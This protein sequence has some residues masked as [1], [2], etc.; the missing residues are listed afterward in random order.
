M[1][2]KS[3]R[4]GLILLLQMF[5]VCAVFM[6]RDTADAACGNGKWIREAKGWWY[7]F[8]D[9]SYA[10]SEYIGGYWLNSKGWYEAK[11]NGSWRQNNKGWWFQAGSWYPKNQ[12]L[13]ING[14]SYYFGADGY[15]VTNRWIGKYYVDGTGAWTKTRSSTQPLVTPGTTQLTA[16]VYPKGSPAAS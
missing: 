12:W 11:W 5:A 6:F 13:K 10:K 8:P 15:M 2:A 16:P 1:R 7:Q 9:G 3:R 4:L 14:K